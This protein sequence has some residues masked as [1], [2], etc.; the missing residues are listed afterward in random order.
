M[1]LCTSPR[2]AYIPLPEGAQ[3]VVSYTEFGSVFENVLYFT[4][5]GGWDAAALQDLADSVQVNFAANMG[6]VVSSDAS[7]IHV[8]AIDVSSAIGP[9]ADNS[10]ASAG[11]RVNPGLPGNVTLAIKFTTALRGR[12]YRGRM[13]LV[14]LSEDMVLGQAVDAAV[15]PDIL[16]GVQSWIE[17]V[18]ADSGGVHVVASY[19][20]LSEWLVA[21]VAT[22]VTG[23]SSDGF[24]DSQR[25]RLAGRGI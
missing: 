5:A 16:L 4:K 15:L 18:E 22:P 12:S 14:G 17:A 2:P 13:Y 24:I 11:L 19:C 6:G 9:V 8:R 23:Y 7:L 25:R 10:A 21:A 3:V 1:T 20:Q